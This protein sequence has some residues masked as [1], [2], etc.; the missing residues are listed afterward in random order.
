MAQFDDAFQR[1]MGHEGGYVHDPD[2]AGGETYRGIA[3]NHHPDWEGWERIDAL[4]ASGEFPDSIDDRALEAE[5]RE[6]YRAQYWKRFQGD[7]IRSQAVAGE[8]FDTAVNMGVRRA[9]RFLQQALNLLNRNG[10]SWPEIVEDGV[11]GPATLGTLQTCLDSGDE[12][13]LLT[14]VN[15]LQGMHYID[16]M[17]RSPVQEKYARGWFRRVEVRKRED[18]GQTPISS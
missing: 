10:D 9:V 17:R 8:L 14:A 6:F 18:Q 2:D 7:R 3:R 11:F 1:T 12:R 13:P 16:Y 15:V 5:V 4:K